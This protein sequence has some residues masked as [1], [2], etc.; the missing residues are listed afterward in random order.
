M[1]VLLIQANTKLVIFIMTAGFC[2]LLVGR[3]EEFRKPQTTKF[4]SWGK[5]YVL[6]CANVLISPALSPT[7]VVT[8]ADFFKPCAVVT[9]AEVFAE[10]PI[11]VFVQFFPM[12]SD[13]CTIFLMQ[14]TLQ[15]LV[16][17]AWSCRWFCFPSLEKLP[18][19]HI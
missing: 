19:K 5:V 17:H 15:P 14:V 8:K 4:L 16:F 6:M 1:T 13:I 7:A 18:I 10:T 12:S 11:V 3:W 2:L 9:Q